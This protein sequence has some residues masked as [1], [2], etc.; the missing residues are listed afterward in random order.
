[1]ELLLP[2]VEYLCQPAPRAQP[3]TSRTLTQVALAVRKGKKRVRGRF[4]NSPT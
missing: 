1:M 2:S 3:G 4:L